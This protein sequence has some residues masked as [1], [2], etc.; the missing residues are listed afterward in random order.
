MQE[1]VTLRLLPAAAVGSETHVGGG[2]GG[3]R[4]EDGYAS[5]VEGRCLDCHRP[6]PDVMMEVRSTEVTDANTEALRLPRR[7]RFDCY[8]QLPEVMTEV[9]SKEATEVADTDS[10]EVTRLEAADAEGGD[11]STPATAA[12]GSG[13]VLMVVTKVTDA[14]ALR[15]PRRRRLECHHQ[16]LEVMTEVRWTEVTEVTDVNAEVLRLP[17]RRRLNCHRQLLEVMTEVHSHKR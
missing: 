10:I 12:D 1:A 14:E 13:A 3:S 9:Q 15:L 17:M 4:R 7:R 2:H 5:T 8:R 11:A 16:L 6:L